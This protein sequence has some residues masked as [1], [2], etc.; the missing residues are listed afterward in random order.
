MRNRR[1]GD[2][3]ERNRR[4][5]ESEMGVFHMHFGCHVVER[6]WSVASAKDITPTT[7]GVDA[8]LT[9]LHMLREVEDVVGDAVALLTLARRCSRVVSGVSCAERRKVSFL[10]GPSS[11]D[12][13]TAAT[14]PETLGASSRLTLLQTFPLCADRQTQAGTFVTCQS[15]SRKYWCCIRE[16]WLL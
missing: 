8:T 15:S 7:A 14:G 4:R 9:C 6:N 16:R 3:V 11:A 13:G 2:L 12:L 5:R 1:L 10:A